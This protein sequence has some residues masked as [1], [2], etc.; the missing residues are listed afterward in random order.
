MSLPTYDT[1]IPT[2][3]Q[4]RT[5]VTD[6]WMTEVVPHLPPALEPQAQALAA[7]QRNRGVA[8][9]SD[10]LRALLAYVLCVSSFRLLGA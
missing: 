7:L 3:I 9:A 6:A 5:L 2:P 1:P 8:C 4:S 10:L